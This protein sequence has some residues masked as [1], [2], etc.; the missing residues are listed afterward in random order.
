MGQATHKGVQITDILF[1]YACNKNQ[2]DNQTHPVDT[3]PLNGGELPDYELTFRH[4]QCP[5]TKSPLSL[6]ERA[7]KVFIINVLSFFY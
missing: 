3:S 7:S 2:E 5:K 6:T 1:L 4:A